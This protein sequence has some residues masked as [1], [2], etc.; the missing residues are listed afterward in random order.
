MPVWNGTYV[1]LVKEL[2]EI[3]KRGVFTLR[4]VCFIALFSSLDAFVIVLLAL[5]TLYSI[6][7]G[8]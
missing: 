8:R 3:R 5:R 1:T 2:P 6:E 4:F 7:G